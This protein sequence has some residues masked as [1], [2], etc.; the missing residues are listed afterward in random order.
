MQYPAP[1]ALTRHLGLE[2]TYNLR[3]LGGYRTLDG[4]TTRWRTFFRS[5]SLHRLPPAAQTTLLDYGVRM[6]IDL[7]RSDELRVAPNVFAGSPVVTYHQISLLMDTPPRRGARPRPLVETYRM[8]LDE[9]Q[10][11]LRQALAT[12]AAPGGCQRWCTVRLGRIAP[13]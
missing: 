5:D 12:L 4:R 8:I 3:D 10:E 6:I 1:P 11:S 2:G 7:R 13:G 9:R